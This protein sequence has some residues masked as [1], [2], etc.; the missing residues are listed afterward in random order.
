MTGAILARITK[1][2]KNGMTK[3]RAIIIWFG[4]AQAIYATDIAVPSPAEMLSQ[5]EVVAVATLSRG[6]ESWLLT[7]NESVKGFCTKGDKWALTSP[8]SEEAFSFDYLSRLVGSGEFLFVG[9]LQKTTKT[10]EPTFGICS[11]W[12]QGTTKELLPERTLAEAVAYAKR[13]LGVIDQTQTAKGSDDSSSPKS[14]T[15]INPDEI[16][17]PPPVAQLSATKKA[18]EA[19]P[20]PTPSEEPAPSTRW[21]IIVVLIV[22]ASGLLW[23]LLKSRK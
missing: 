21:S 17:K 16:R 10:L 4:L 3:L 19:E 2:S 6:Q 22:A 13:H 12:P 23:M 5:S 14:S 7:I 1:P 11:V 18:P 20:A 9:R 15:Q 8:Y